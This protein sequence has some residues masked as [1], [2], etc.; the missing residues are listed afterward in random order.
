MKLT[1][2]TSDDRMVTDLMGG[3]SRRDR[4]R[5]LQLMH[6]AHV[7]GGQV[8]ATEGARGREFFVLTEGRVEVIVAGETV[9]EV[10]PGDFFGE[11]ALLG[12]GYRTATV[13]AGDDV[14]LEVMNRREFAS[15]LDMWPQFANEVTRRATRRMSRLVG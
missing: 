7:S 9:A 15:V 14:R 11:I 4:R 6:P 2:G 12:D 1:W 10:E 5:V 13:V 8:L 3:V